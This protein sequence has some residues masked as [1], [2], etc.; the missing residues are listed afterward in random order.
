DQ[1]LGAPD[2]LELP[3]DRPRGAI[4]SFRGAKVKF[5]LPADLSDALRKLGQ[6][7]KSTLFMVALAAF[8]LLLSRWSGQRDIVVGV[9]IAGRSRRETEGLIGSFLNMLALRTYVDEANTFCQLL[10]RVKTKT[11]GA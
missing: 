6:R 11:L 1:L 4:E 3:S 8:Q 9:P 7:E 2:Q 5:Q 10:E